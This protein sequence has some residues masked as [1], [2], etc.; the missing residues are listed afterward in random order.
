[1]YCY[2]FEIYNCVGLWNSHIN[3]AHSNY[4][5]FFGGGGGERL[6]FMGQN[7]KN[8]HFFPILTPLSTCTA[9][10]DNGVY[11]RT[12]ATCPCNK[13]CLGRAEQ[14]GWWPLRFQ[15]TYDGT[16]I[17]QSARSTQYALTQTTVT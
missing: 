15:C 11:I 4:Y 8:K 10:S 7:N 6:F 5:F 13:M 14:V 12:C 2:S 17:Q 9:T 1:M 16:Y 3:L